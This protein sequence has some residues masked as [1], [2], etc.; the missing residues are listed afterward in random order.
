MHLVMHP[1]NRLLSRI[2]IMI[3]RANEPFPKEFMEKYKRDFVK[4]KDALDGVHVFKEP[5][6]DIGAHPEI[7]AHFE[8]YFAARQLA[9]I[10][11]SSLLDIGSIRYFVI[12][13]LAHYN[14]TTI[15]IRPRTPLCENETVVTC[16]AKKLDIPDGSF[17][18]VV[19]ICALEHFGLGRYGDEIDLD[20]DKK[21]FRE[22]V[23]VLKPGGR[24]VFTTTLSKG[25]PSVAF[26]AHR[27]YTLDMLRGFCSGLSC[28]EE[29][30]YSVRMNRYCTFDEVTSNPE[31]WDIY[32]G[33]WRKG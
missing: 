19:S 32:C 14:V 7:S 27:I 28:E 30:F 24:L 21:G 5:W 16:D 2:G 1:V 8:C 3:N 26:N 11:P 12:G 31:E 20:G 22:F 33:C 10:Q 29:M 17:D 6:C 9:R 23:R 13:L 25:G 4:V 18:A 15:D